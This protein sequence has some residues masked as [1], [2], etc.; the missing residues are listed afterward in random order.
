MGCF[1]QDVALASGPSLP[2][3]CGFC[4]HLIEYPLVENVRRE[5]GE[6]QQPEDEPVDNKLPPLHP[7]RESLHWGRM[8]HKAMDE[9][10]ELAEKGGEA[11]QAANYILDILDN[12]RKWLLQDGPLAEGMVLPALWELINSRRLEP[13]LPGNI[14]T[15][16][17][18]LREK[19]AVNAHLHAIEAKPGSE[20]EAMDAFKA[21]CEMQLNCEYDLLVHSRMMQAYHKTMKGEVLF[22][23]FSQR[24]KYRRG[25]VRKAREPRIR[26]WAGTE[27]W[28]RQ[29]EEYTLREGSL[30]EQAIYTQRS[31][32]K[33]TNARL[34][35]A[36]IGYRAEEIDEESTPILPYPVINGEW[37]TGF[38]AARAWQV[39]LETNM[40]PEY[41]GGAQNYTPDQQSM[42]L[43]SFT[44]VAENKF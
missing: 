26:Q 9:L 8:V 24:V 35:P 4:G 19:I 37:T 36:F 17:R 10:L 13:W 44:E 12:V 2:C 16:E 15:M 7:I 27:E 34:L 11:E 20:A 23:S 25:G 43:K 14:R 33:V 30:A 21:Y 39:R 42:T 28:V 5:H 40:L 41:I 22:R 32:K 18:E 1:A 38:F 29:N 3:R 31:C 6:D